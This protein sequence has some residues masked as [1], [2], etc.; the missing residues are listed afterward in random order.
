MK[1]WVKIAIVVA[2]ILVIFFV[3][4]KISNAIEVARA[5]RE[6][7]KYSITGGSGASSY[8]LNPATVAQEI[9]SA[10]HEYWGMEDEERAMTAILNVPKAFVKSVSDAYYS[11][12]KLQ[13]SSEF[14]KYLS[15]EE[16]VKVRSQFN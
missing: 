10:F 3:Y 7:D 16:Y 11:L 6:F 4:K 5:K 2:I 13:L 1:L 14:I 12:Y 15:P 9:Y 8:S